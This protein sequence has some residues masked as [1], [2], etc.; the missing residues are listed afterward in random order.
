MK[1][2]GAFLLC[3]TFSIFLTVVTATAQAPVSL[4]NGGNAAIFGVLAGSGMTNTRPTTITGDVGSSPT[5]TETGFTPCPAADCVN[6]TGTNHNAADP[7]DA[8][9]QGAKT[10]LRNAYL[11]A[12]GRFPPITTYPPIHD[13]GGAVLT[14]GV[15]NDPSSFAVT[16]TLTLDFQ[17]DPNAVFIFQAGSTLTT[18]A[19]NSTIKLINNAGGTGCNVFWQVGSAAT[20]NTGAN[21]VGT[22]LAHDDIS[23]S[24]GVTVAGR[25]LAGA[26]ASGAGA[27]TLN[28]DSI[29]ASVCGAPPPPPPSP[30]A[31]TCPANAGQVSVAY[32]SFTVGS[33]GTPSYTYSVASGALPAG[34]TLNTSTGAMTGTPTTAGPFSFTTRVTDSLGATATSPSCGIT[35]ALSPPPLQLPDLTITKTHSGNFQLGGSGAYTLT[36]TN[37]GAGPTSGA[38]TVSDAL[39][40]GLTATAI[41][42]TGWSCVLIG[43]R[44]TR[45]DVLDGGS[46]PAI[47]VTV[48]VANNIL[49][50]NQSGSGLTFQPGDIL[51]SMKDGTL[52]WRRHDWTLVKTVTSGTDGQAKGMGF[53]ASG[54]LFL[55]HYYGTGFSGNDVVK[56]NPNG[57]LIGTFG[58]GY[59]CNPAS[60][61]FDNAGN[62]FVGHADCSGNIFKF[63]SQGN[64][65]AQYDVA[66][67]NR[68]SSHILLGSDQCTMYYTSE[69]PDVKRFNV[70]TKTQMPDFN[71]APLP[72][73]I[74]G[75]QQFA[76]LPGD[77]LLVANFSVIARLDASGNLVRTYDAPGDTHCWLG[78]SLD[79]DGL[80]FWASNW[81]GSF[82]TRFDLATG[83]VIESHVASDTG[84]MV[85][86]IMV[87]PQGTSIVINTA[88]VS[89]GG[90]VNF[91]NNSASDP[92]TIAANQLQTTVL[93]PLLTISSAGYCAGVPWSVAASNAMPNVTV[94]LMGT[95]NGQSWTTPDWATANAA[96]HFVVGGV[97]PDGIQGNSYT[98]RIASGGKM[99]NTIG[100]AMV[101]CTP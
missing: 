73:G 35:I 97:F 88:A 66:L 22:I 39:P 28:N 4:N 52:Q 19:T 6:L 81:C 34:L 76:L 62:A 56:F 64:L 91:S 14:P 63:D 2:L 70:C 5:H 17:G 45:N 25:L 10:A 31:L 32:S 95:V 79:P 93:T 3:A 67:E 58:T 44:C 40:A 61:V 55:T 1:R 7:N 23:V 48:N 69:G 46:Y 37:I 24:A 18:A 43:L 30:L 41:S 82:A 36:V 65:L 15:Y 74:E 9:T 71:T 101:A 87:V 85:K 59:D 57:N 80:S 84:F 42:G 8:V 77:G 96:G 72:D 92:T 98:L 38:V 68:G 21:F 50:S 51:L 33:G 83:K 29:T 47:T 90:V 53:D 100:F 16:G 99:S 60:I 75:A 86:Q 20:L 27:V 12:Q 54:N 26:Q 13:L 49:T 94:T 11:D 78:M 89:G